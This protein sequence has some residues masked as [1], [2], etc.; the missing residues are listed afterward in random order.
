MPSSSRPRVAFQVMDRAERL[1][2][3]ALRR[4][5]G[6]YGEVLCACLRA[7][8]SR[9]PQSVE[10]EFAKKSTTQKV[11]DSWTGTSSDLPLYRP[12]ELIDATKRDAGLPFLCYVDNFGHVANTFDDLAAFVSFVTD[13][14]SA[15]ISSSALCW[16]G[17]RGVFAQLQCSQKVDQERVISKVM[18]AQYLGQ[19]LSCSSIVGGEYSGTS[20]ASSR[21]DWAM[22]TGEAALVGVEVKEGK[23]LAKAEKQRARMM[24]VLQAKAE[25]KQKKQKKLDKLKTLGMPSPSKKEKKKHKKQRKADQLGKKIRSKSRH[26]D[27]IDKIKK[28]MKKRKRLT[29]DSESGSAASSFSSSSRSCSGNS[30]SDSSSKS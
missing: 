20:S 1:G 24:K 28:K 15:T 16:S 6:V 4:E 27:K 30:D 23:R 5:F 18:N 12:D 2:L 11:K 9:Q 10:I 7:D 14:C 21:V 22:V 8:S 17:S 26:K 3:R 29:S 19:K 25:K 13:S